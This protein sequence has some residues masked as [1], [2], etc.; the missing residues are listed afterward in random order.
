MLLLRLL[1]PERHLLLD[2]GDEFLP[3]EGQEVDH[4]VDA[5]KEL[6]PAEVGLQNWLNNCEDE[7]HEA[8]QNDEMMHVGQISCWLKQTLELAL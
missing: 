1:G 6:V 4:L 3:R 5:P 2:E 8:M 7:L